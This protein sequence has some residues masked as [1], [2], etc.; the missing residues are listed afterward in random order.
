M[1]LS[2][3]SIIVPIYN[4]ELFLKKT[5]ES[6]LNQTYKNLEVILVNDG[7]TDN[8]L[9]ICQYYEKLD[10]RIIIINQKNS[11]VSSAR[12][13]G[14]ECATGDFIGFVDSDDYIDIEMFEKMLKKAVEMEADIVECG[15]FTV[16]LE[17]GAKT[18]FPLKSQVISGKE[19]CIKSYL[20]GLNTT[21]FNVNKLYKASLINGLRYP[22]YKYSEDYWFNSQA[23]NKCKVKVTIEE[24]LYYYVQ[25]NE[26][27]V[28]KEFNLEERMDVI[29]AGIDVYNFVK[30]SHPGLESYPAYYICNNII[31][32]ITC[33]WRINHDKVNYLRQLFNDYYKNIDKNIINKRKRMKLLICKFHP[34]I[35]IFMNK[36]IKIYNEIK[37]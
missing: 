3:I 25:H 20:S 8:S 22:D 12:N 9:K 19:N 37:K 4:S 23:F 27:A 28:R 17:S 21:N 5:I 10:S 2:K 33:E 31:N 6:I 13:A 15:Y 18:K 34:L 32:F 14:L 16:D 35:Y 11:G 1:Y 26:S 29:R 36:L 30:N 24:P 7:S